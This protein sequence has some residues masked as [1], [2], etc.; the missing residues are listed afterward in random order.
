[1]IGAWIGTDQEKKITMVQPLQ[2]DG[3]CSRTQ[4][5]REPHTACLVAIKRA[6]I[7]MAGSVYA[8]KELQQK[9]RFV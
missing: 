9:S 2:F 4:G 1:M 3:G 7:N 6:I 8:G 5:T